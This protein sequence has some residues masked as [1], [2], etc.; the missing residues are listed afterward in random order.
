VGHSGKKPTPNGTWS[1]F[2]E[3]IS[4][5]QTRLIAR[6]LGGNRRQPLLQR[7]F[8]RYVMVPTH[9]VMERRMLLG[10]KER[11]EGQSASIA[12]DVVEV[13]PWF[14]AAALTIA[15]AVGTV[16]D[17]PGWWV[18]VFAADASALLVLPLLRPPIVL[19]FAWVLVGAAVAIAAI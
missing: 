8:E 16:A 13:I 12:H 17:G 11:A 14:A 10:I 3:P 7:L 1:F 5:D 19:S 4:R 2:L 15:G 18:A 6:G 9:F